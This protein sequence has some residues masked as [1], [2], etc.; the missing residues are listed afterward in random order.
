M[1]FC[2]LLLFVSFSN[3]TSELDVPWDIVEAEEILVSTYN[4]VLDAEESGANVS[5]LLSKL[6]TGAEYLNQAYLQI[7]LEDFESTV[8]FSGLCINAVDG[9]SEQA[10]LLKDEAVEFRN[11]ELLIQIF[12]SIVGIG[13][14]IVGGIIFWK[15]FKRYYL[16]G[17]S[18][19][20]PEV[21]D[22]ES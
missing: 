10:V 17:I 9:V 3:A 14:V 15:V 11:G 16:D 22:S 7:G 8:Y 21:S 12:G 6:D 19:L 4:H 2:S 18:K 13:V 20:K 1:F 5:D